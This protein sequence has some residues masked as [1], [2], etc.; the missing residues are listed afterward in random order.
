M[1]SA[2]AGVRS[3]SASG[4]DIRSRRVHPPR[5]CGR[6]LFKEP[7]V[8]QGD[9]REAGR[10]TAARPENGTV[11]PGLVGRTAPPAALI[12]LGPC[13]PSR[14]R[15]DLVLPPQSRILRRHRPLCDHRRRRRGH[16]HVDGL[17]D[18][19]SS[20][21]RVGD[22]R[23]LAGADRRR[24]EAPGDRRRVE[25]DCIAKRKRIEM[26]V[27]RS[28]GERLFF[29]GW[30]RRETP[31]SKSRARSTGWLPDSTLPR[32]SPISATTASKAGDG[33]CFTTPFIWLA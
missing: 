22:P 23:N 17:C 15:R 7:R 33:H 3:R 28:E 26:L 18:L 21:G 24:S 27:T 5:G 2:L 25:L 1:V 4:R 10:R 9:Q 32:S 8:R 16:D 31:G 13:G 6:P 30:T 14:P 19:G 11:C 29:V 20:S 12:S